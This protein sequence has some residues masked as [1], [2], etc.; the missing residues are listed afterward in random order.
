M[1]HRSLLKGLLGLLSLELVGLALL[2]GEVLLVGTKDVVP[3][4]E[5]GR[6]V[7]CEGHVVIIVVLRTGPEG[8]PVVGGPGEIVT[9]MS[10]N[11]LEETQGHPSQGGNQMQ[12]VGEEAPDQGTANRSSAQNDDLNRVSILGSETKGSGPFVVQLVDVL[13]E[14][15]VV[16]TA[17]SPIVEEILEDKEQGNLEDHLGAI[18]VKKKKKVG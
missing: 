1:G 6:E 9:R 11:S 14:G 15:S 7:I 17:V 8:Q 2:V 18:E 4:P 3:P 12:I 10:L 5:A 16:E 13:V